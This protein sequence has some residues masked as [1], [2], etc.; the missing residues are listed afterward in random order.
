LAAVNWLCR[1][2]GIR[3]ALPTAIVGDATAATATPP[4]LSTALNCF[5]FPVAHFPVSSLLGLPARYGPIRLV[6]K[7]AD[8]ARRP[9]PRQPPPDAKPADTST[10]VLEGRARGERKLNEVEQR[11]DSLMEVAK[12]KPKQV[13]KQGLSEYFLFTIEG[14]EDIKDKEPKRLVAL[15]VADVPLESIYKLSDRD[16]GQQFTKFYRFKNVKLL[17]DQ[18]KEKK[19]SAMENLGLSPLPNGTVRHFSEYK[20]K[21]LA[22]VGG[23]ETKYVPIGDRVEV[24]VGPDK[25][26]TVSRRLKDQKIGNVVARQ[27]KRRLDDKFV[28]YCPANS[29]RAQ[30]VARFNAYY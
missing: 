11:F 13:V 16:S 15:K 4:A 29:S 23:T 8:L 5:H 21:D 10:P 19:L 1:C 22:Y 14:R 3:R 20:N 12:D 17:D 9:P 2:R 6:E 26:I 18:G 27:Y 25:D 7:I 30:M 24:N 28:L